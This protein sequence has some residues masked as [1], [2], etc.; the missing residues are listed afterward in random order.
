LEL[1]T[2]ARE[3]ADTV[4][5]VYVGPDAETIAPALGEDGAAKVY[6]VDPQGVLSG[7]AGAA[8]L[9]PLIE[10]NSP[11]L[12]LFAQT[13]DGRDAVARLSAKPYP[14]GIT[15]STALSAPET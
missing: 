7:V 4:E 3:I 12:V 5:A 11:D 2:K 14:P 9:A 1:L 13:Y 15:T 6:A 10:A 8:A